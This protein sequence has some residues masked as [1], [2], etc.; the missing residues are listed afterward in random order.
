MTAVVHCDGG[1]YERRYAKITLH[2]HTLF[3]AFHL[4][5]KVT[6]LVWL[7]LCIHQVVHHVLEQQCLDY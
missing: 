3:R 1:S 2:L 4:T 5:T 7:R 6:W